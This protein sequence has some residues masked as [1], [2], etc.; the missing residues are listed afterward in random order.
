MD[1]AEEFAQHIA[2]AGGHAQ[3]SLL[4]A[5]G[6]QPGDLLRGD[7]A[8]ELAALRAAMPSLTAKTK[9]ASRS[10]LSPILPR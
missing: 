6:Q 5:L 9:S 2:E 3:C 10:E 7:L 4:E 1:V 8:G